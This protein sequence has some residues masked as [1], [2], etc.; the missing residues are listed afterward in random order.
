MNSHL[1]K[2][3]TSVA[4]VIAM[5]A[6]LAGCSHFSEKRSQCLT[7]EA[8][9]ASQSAIAVRLHADPVHLRAVIAMPSDSAP[10]S[11]PETVG[12]PSRRSKVDNIVI[13]IGASFP[14]ALDVFIGEPN[15]DINELARRLSLPIN[16]NRSLIVQLVDASTGTPFI[17]DVPQLL[18]AVPTNQRARCLASVLDAATRVHT[19]TF[20]SKLSRS[21]LSGAL[22]VDQ[23]SRRI[24]LAFTNSNLPKPQQIEASI[25]QASSLRNAAST[26]SDPVNIAVRNLTNYSTEELAASILRNYGKTLSRQ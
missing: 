19:A 25:T 16:K 3:T 20:S 4:A 7:T 15:L 14:E 6:L 2:G 23:M 21:W 18:S 24:D 17:F 1:P 10:Y 26:D 22:A 9:I 13:T 12:A 8:A 11:T 5:S